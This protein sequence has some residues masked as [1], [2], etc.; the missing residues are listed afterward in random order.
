MEIEK[1]NIIDTLDSYF[2]NE[3]SKDEEQELKEL[4]LQDPEI[5]EQSMLLAKIAQKIRMRQ[6]V[7]EQSLYSRQS[8]IRYKW[9]V[10][11][12][13]VLLIIVIT[14]LVGKFYMTNQLFQSN[15][16]EYIPDTST[17]GVDSLSEKEKK[18]F[19][20][21]NEIGIKKSESIL[22][23]KNYLEMEKSDYQISLYDADIHWYLALAYIK[24]NK[25]KDAINECEYIISKHPDSSY[26]SS[27]HT[28]I[29]KIKAIPFI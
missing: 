8:R 12:A 23:L 7:Y 1:N 5:K 6:Q 17:R 19:R 10:I 29:D 4:I 13:A 24:S 25:L 21:F 18:L 2:N 15:Y 22:V 14:D 20:T 3:L 9:V 27:A 11:V 26:V 16:T 28:L